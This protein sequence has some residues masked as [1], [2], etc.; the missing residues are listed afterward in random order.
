MWP[1]MREACL[2]V[3][4]G[5]RRAW[6]LAGVL[7]VEDERERVEDDGV[8]G[9]GLD[10][11]EAEGGLAI[12]REVDLSEDAVDRVPVVGGGGVVGVRRHDEVDGGPFVLADGA[13][14]HV[15][16]A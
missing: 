6:G 15:V 4:E 10:K 11:A 2:W 3:S 7:T 14:A 16:V 1:R 13:E 5:K 8:V 9:V 12:G